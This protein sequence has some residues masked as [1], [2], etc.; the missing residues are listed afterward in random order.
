MDGMLKRVVGQVVVEASAYHTPEAMAAPHRPVAEDAP[1]PRPR[2]MQRDALLLLLT[3]GI[4][5]PKQVAAG[6]EIARVYAAFVRG[7]AARVSAG[8]GER[9]DRGAEAELPVALG[10]A[11][12]TRYAPWR[13]WAGGIAV[14]PRKSLADLT[15]LVCVDGLGPRQAGEALGMDHRTVKRRLQA[16]LH[17]YCSNAGWLTEREA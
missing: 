1:P 9:L 2:P 15:L 5:T 14:T 7:I 12:A 16:S 17:W 8:Y 13:T 6:Q 4:L 11:S 3:A 10:I